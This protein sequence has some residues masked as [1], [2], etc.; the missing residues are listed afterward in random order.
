M[1]AAQ[2]S[3]TGMLDRRRALLA[4]SGLVTAG[5]LGD[6]LEPTTPDQLLDFAHTIDGAF[7][8]LPA[9]QIAYL[10]RHADKHGRMILAD[11]D[12]GSPDYVKACTAVGVLGATRAAALFDLGERTRANTLYGKVFDDLGR[13][14]HPEGQLWVLGR[15]V[16]HEAL[17][18]RPMLAITQAAQA[19]GFAVR[20]GLVGHP[21]W[22]RLLV[23]AEARALIATR[24]IDRAESVLE[25]AA[26]VMTAA[27]P[28]P[29]IGLHQKG[30]SVAEFSV[31][32][33]TRY[34]E[35]ADAEPRQSDAGD[36]RTQAVSYAVAT[37]PDLDMAGA[38]GLRS[39]ARLELAR[40]VLDDDP[41]TAADLLIDVADVSQRRPVDHLIGQYHTLARTI[42]DRDVRLGRQLADRLREWR[43]PTPGGG[44]T[45]RF[46]A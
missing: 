5:L 30:M 16:I 35:L 9:R 38:T 22:V 1:D 4:G 7:E 32:M 43:G 6:M 12:R 27:P 42:A 11:C 23:Q 24:Q 19:R 36:D 15:Q 31:S 13:G 14:E 21:S 34:N 39:Y 29:V 33:A 45:R 10:T 40:V 18:A 28:T 25:E 20:H 17:Q 46:F 8:Y 2:P 37:W 26:D 44:V 41:D 3:A